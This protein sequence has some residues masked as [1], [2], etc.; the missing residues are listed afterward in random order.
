M[1]I[2]NKIDLKIKNI[3]R[4]KEG[5]YIMIKR[6]IQED[7]TAINI[8]APNLGA[9]QYLRLTT[10]NGEI[11][12]NTIIERNFNTPLIPMDKSFRQKVNQETQALNDTLDHLDLL[13]IYSIFQPKTVDFTFFSSAQEHSPGYIIC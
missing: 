10:M 4:D 13:D 11:D 2:S 6:S 12:S 1:L 5:H 3:T 7:I 8:Y 9:P